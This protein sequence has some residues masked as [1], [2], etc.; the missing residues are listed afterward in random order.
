M[1]S[2]DAQTPADAAGSAEP[3]SPPED[4]FRRLRP[5]ASAPPAA[6]VVARSLPLLGVAGVVLTL[7]AAVGVVRG[8]L[9]VVGAI[10]SASPTGA[11]ALVTISLW[12][13]SLL[14]KVPQWQADAWARSGNANPRELFEIEH[15]S[16][17]TLG[18]ILSGV[19]VITGLNFAWQQLGQ[20]SDN[21]R[22]SQ[23]GRITD[24]FTRAV[25]QLGSDDLTVRL[26]GICALER[27]AGDC[28]RDYSAG[29][30]D[31]A[32][33]SERSDL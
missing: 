8:Q 28:P 18:Q 12:A 16:R 32:L 20:T 27:I 26:G 14:W 33:E 24:R 19:A 6:A 21:V 4:H 3:L 11:L 17:G 7:L 25:D 29:R 5:R 13:V 23:E 22:V 30:P 1:A 31:D 15:A 10:E 2:S 9:P